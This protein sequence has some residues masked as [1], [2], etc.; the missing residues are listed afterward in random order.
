MQEARQ[1]HN[2][3]DSVALCTKDLVLCAM[4]NS[5]VLAGVFY[6]AN[7]N[8]LVKNKITTAVRICERK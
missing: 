4:I 5:S 8:R 7:G 2:V 6:S 3:I 1:S